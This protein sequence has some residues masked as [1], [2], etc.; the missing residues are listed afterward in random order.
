MLLSSSSSS[1]GRRRPATS[2]IVVVASFLLLLLDSTA[3]AVSTTTKDNQVDVEVGATT[4]VVLLPTAADRHPLSRIRRTSSSGGNNANRNNRRRLLGPTTTQHEEME[5]KAD[6]RRRD[7]QE[8]QQD[9]KEER[10]R[11]QRQWEMAG[12]PMYHLRSFVD[13]EEEEDTEDDGDGPTKRRAQEDADG[14]TK[15]CSRITV[16]VLPSEYDVDYKSGGSDLQYGQTPIYANV[17]S[18]TNDELV[19]IGTW[20]WE[21]IDDQYGTMLIYYNQRESLFFGFTARQTYYP[22]SGGFRFQNQCPHG[23]ASF[24]KYDETRELRYYRLYL[25]NACQE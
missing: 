1:T 18:S 11:L 9:D 22:V 6:R 16:V 17:D 4:E 25:C 3:A 15:L 14:T 21:W 5:E 8:E 13:H 7:L 23:Y 24:L 10:L 19:E 20:Y 2:A 12:H